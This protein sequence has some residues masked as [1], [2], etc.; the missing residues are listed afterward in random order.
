MSWRS[1]RTVVLAPDDLLIP[2]SGKR[3]GCS[4][5]GRRRKARRTL[6][7]P[8]CANM[9]RRQLVR[10]VQQRGAPTVYE[11]PRE[12]LGLDSLEG[13]S[14]RLEH[15]VPCAGC[16]AFIV[17]E[18]SRL[19]P[20]RPEKTPTR[21]A[22]HRHDGARRNRGAG[23]HGFLHTVACRRGAFWHMVTR[24]PPVSQTAIMHR[25]ALPVTRR[26]P[27][28]ESIVFVRD[29]H[30]KRLCRRRGATSEEES[31]PW[32]PF[33]RAPRSWSWSCKK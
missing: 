21:K 17:A 27:P 25:L 11:T 30:N 2:S 14:F 28:F 5:N 20:P 18:R 31:R 1:P 6:P 4:W 15:H 8:R 13:R 32:P 19:F 33:W 29:R 7:R 9:S 22:S 16:F 12:S 23:I 24:W 26:R 10:R 3:S